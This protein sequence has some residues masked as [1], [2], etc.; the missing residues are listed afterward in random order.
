MERVFDP[1]KLDQVFE[2]HAVRGYSTDLTF[3]QGVSLRS[4]VRLQSCPRGAPGT[5]RLK[6]RCP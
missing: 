1:A 2:D 3:A 4:D 6:T 5:K